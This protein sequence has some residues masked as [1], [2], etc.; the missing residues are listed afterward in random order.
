A[1]GVSSG[2]L[3]GFGTNYLDFAQ[4]TVDAGA[5]W[6]LVSDAIGA[7]YGIEIGGTLTNTGSIG[8]VVRL[9]TNGVL[10]NAA[11]G[12]IETPAATAVYANNDGSVVNH[13][14]ISAGSRGIALSG[15]ASATNASDGT[16]IASS[17][18]I[19]GTGGAVTAVNQGAI[20]G[21]LF[22]IYL[23]SGGSVTN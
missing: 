17:F 19:S 12:T 16:I 4:I 21:D 2:T 9:D 6:T 13:G 10:T 1:S 18:G 14:L 3:T 8:S 15:G 11:T 7:S 23:A 22:S 5:N 20:T